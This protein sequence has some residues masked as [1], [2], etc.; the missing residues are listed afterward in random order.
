MVSRMMAS[1]GAIRYGRKASAISAMPKPARPITKLA[2]AM[3]AAA[4]TQASVTRSRS[5]ARGRRPPRVERWQVGARPE[6]E[7]RRALL[8]EGGNALASVGGTTGP[9]RAHGVEPVRLA[10]MTGAQEL[11]HH[12]A[13]QGDRDRGR[14]GRDLARELARRRQQRVRRYDTAHEPAGQGLLGGEDTACVDPLGGL[15]DPHEARQEPRAA[16]LGHD[17]AAGEDEAHARRG[18]G[19]PDVHGQGQRDP[20]SHGGPPGRR[21]PGPLYFADP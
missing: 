20:E 21:D 15:A 14:V 10:R 8:E 13:R 19:D 9:E 1:A 2:A 5:V 11:P 4:A 3:T 7:A 16:R 6:G 17:A 18:G 12:L